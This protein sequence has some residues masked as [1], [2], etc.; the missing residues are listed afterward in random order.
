MAQANLCMPRTS[1][2]GKAPGWSV[3]GKDNHHPIVLGTNPDP[4]EAG[5][6]H[7]LGE[8]GACEVGENEGWYQVRDADGQ[9]D[10]IACGVGVDMALGYSIWMVG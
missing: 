3:G 5:I 7:V 8:M 9:Y 4:G 1:S 2:T 6:V 10:C